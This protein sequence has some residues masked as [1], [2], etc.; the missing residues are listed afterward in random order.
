VNDIINPILG[1][2]LAGVDFSDIVITLRAAEGENPAVTI[3]LGMFINAVIQFLIT[4]LVVFLIVKSFNEMNRRLTRQKAVEEAPPPG[5][6]VDEKILT[7]LERLDGTL[8][9]IDTRLGS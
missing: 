9:N 3:N 5:P 2:I 6:S 8:Q 4:A 1:I 7:T